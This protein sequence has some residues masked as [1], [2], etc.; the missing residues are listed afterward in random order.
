[1]SQN[2][3]NKQKS[4][5]LPLLSSVERQ[6][7]I[8]SSTSNET[9]SDYFENSASSRDTG[10]SDSSKGSGGCSLAP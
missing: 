10:D 3:S 8:C 7:S 9:N 5:A 4:K 6:E 2:K 1:M